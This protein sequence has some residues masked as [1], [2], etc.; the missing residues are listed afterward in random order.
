MPHLY[1]SAFIFLV[2]TGESTSS[3][4]AL[5]APSFEED[6]DSVISNS[7]LALFNTW[8][9]RGGREREREKGEEEKGEEEEGGTGEER[10]DNNSLKHIVLSNKDNVPV[11]TQKVNQCTLDKTHYIIL[12]L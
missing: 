8:G 1:S 4:T 9:E 12:N 6:E 5:S 11:Q 3:I 2:R 7:L 10:G